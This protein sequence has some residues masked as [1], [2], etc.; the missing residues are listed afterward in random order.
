MAIVVMTLAMATYTRNRIWGNEVRF[1]EDNLAKAPN[2]ARPHFNLGNAYI[3]EHRLTDAI[4]QNYEA[5]R[6]APTRLLKHGPW[7]NIA[8]CLD[9]LQKWDEALDAYE[10]ALQ[11][12]PYEYQTVI[13]YAQL[14]ATVGRYQESN[15]SS[16]LPGV[17][18]QPTTTRS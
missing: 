2:K 15:N 14:L 8:R 9:E 11:I 12:K 4:A 10:I 16:S 6:L 1:W 18:V 13:W 7:H 5:I 3:Y 17:Y